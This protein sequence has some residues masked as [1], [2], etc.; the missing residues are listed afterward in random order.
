M[1]TEVY[2]ALREGG[3]SEEKARK[4]AE[5]LANYDDRFSSVERRLSVMTW[6]IGALA[7]IQAIV[8]V[9]AVWLLLRV[10]AKVGALS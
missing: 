4:A 3:T 7:A 1:I 10:A 9:P 8:G 6:Q 2:D 5:A